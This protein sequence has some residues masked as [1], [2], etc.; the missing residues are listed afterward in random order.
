MPKSTMKNTDVPG[1]AIGSHAA[2]AR[3]MI[4]Q[5]ETLLGMEDVLDHL[6][7]EDVQLRSIS[8]RCPEDD[9][10]EYMA[11]V[12]VFWHGE[13]QVAFHNAPTFLE[14]M[15]GVVNRLKNRSLQFKDDKYE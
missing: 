11:V 13:K 8:I 10:P 12:R 4:R 15:T 14:T 2:Y 9:R 6:F 7:E 5:A 1:S 3:Q